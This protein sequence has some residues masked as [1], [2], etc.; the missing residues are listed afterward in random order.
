MDVSG[1]G[2]HNLDVAGILIHANTIFILA[3]LMRFTRG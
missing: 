3:Q 2:G 1:V